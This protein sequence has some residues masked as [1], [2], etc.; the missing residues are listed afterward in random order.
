[1]TTATGTRTPPEELSAAVRM[2]VRERQLGEVAQPGQ[3]TMQ[4]YAYKEFSLQH[5]PA[6]RCAEFTLEHEA[7]AREGD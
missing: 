4:P 6:L 2:T 1:M 5:A 3:V 7:L